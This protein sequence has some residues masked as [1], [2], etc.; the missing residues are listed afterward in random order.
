MDISSVVTSVAGIAGCPIIW[1]II[2]RNEYRRRTLT[3]LTGSRTVGCYLLAL[4]IFSSSLFRDYLFNCAIKANAGFTLFPP[5]LEQAAFLVGS[6]CIAVGMVLVLSSYYRL[7]ICGTYLGD[8]FGILM[9]ERVTKFP[10]NVL[11]NPMYNGSSLSFL[12]GALCSNSIVGVVLAVWVFVVYEIS[13]NY[14]ENP[15]TTMIYERAAKEKNTEKKT[16]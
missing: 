10:F 2:A 9:S 1:N 16:N 11:E 14:F 6:C 3:A 5:A 7:G 15:F 13:C 8:Y 12:G 4:W